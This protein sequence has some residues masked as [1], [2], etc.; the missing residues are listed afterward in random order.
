M[1]LFEEDLGREVPGEQ[2]S[3]L[4]ANANP[5]L[6]PPSGAGM[7]YWVQ[8]CWWVADHYEIPTALVCC[9]IALV[10]QVQEKMS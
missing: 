7:P 8:W 1:P 6:N 3:F 4:I 5:A 9:Y 10:W 2:V